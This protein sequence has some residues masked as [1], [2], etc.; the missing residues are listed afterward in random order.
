MVE[1][2]KKTN[3]MNNKIDIDILDLYIFFIFRLKEN[4][5][6]WIWILSSCTASTII[7]LLQTPCI[8]LF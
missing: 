5:L 4:I 2:T 6:I 3:S 7:K 8:S 1:I